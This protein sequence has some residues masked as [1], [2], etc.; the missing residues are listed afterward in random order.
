MAFNI[1]N[2]NRQKSN[3]E[4]AKSLKEVLQR[5]IS[6]EKANPKTEEELSR[7]LTQM[8]TVLQGTTEL[9]VSPDQQHGL[10]SA[11][12]QEDVLLYLAKSI[13]RLPFESRKDTQVIM[14][15]AFRFKPPNSPDLDP[16]AINWVVKRRP[17]I[18]TALCYGYDRKESAM[19][20][21]GV[22]RE[23][24][25]HEVVAAI[26][27]YDEPNPDGKPLD[28]ANINLD[29]PVS[30]N[31]VFWNFFDWIDKGAFEVSADAFNTFREL[32]TKHKG[33]V[34]RYLQANF[35]SFF[36]K[37]NKTLVQSESYVTKRQSIK[38]LGEILLD[39]SNYNIMTKYVDIGEHLKIIMRL[40]KDDRKMINYEG[41]HV[42]KKVFVANPNKS[43][44]V[45]KILIGNRDKLLK[46]LPAFLQDRQDDDQFMDEKSFLI[47]QIELLPP[48]PMLTQQPVA[49]NY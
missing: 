14:S 23:A 33:L 1:F 3:P 46:F 26:V 20:C 9:E 36:A 22:L 19:P 11:L 13:H 38:L 42:F 10:I 18:I 41:F 34:A 6:E 2:R 17:E 45:Q 39:R 7:S 4:L 47:R 31:G 29:A 21:G 32:L 37:Y 43:M 48:A 35:D 49:R 27:L 40:L 28:L 5:Y 16:I 25:K 15:S 12:L 30:G 44:E 24:L 8:K